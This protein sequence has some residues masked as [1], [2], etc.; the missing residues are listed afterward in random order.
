MVLYIHQYIYCYSSN[1]RHKVL[2]LKCGCEGFW[3]D[4][5]NSIVS[6]IYDSIFQEG[7]LQEIRDVGEC[8]ESLQNYGI[9]LDAESFSSEGDTE[10]CV[11][12]PK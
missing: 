5:R 12:D 1:K 11:Q 10:S 6:E 4:S 9:L 3:F 8:V 7:K 2:L